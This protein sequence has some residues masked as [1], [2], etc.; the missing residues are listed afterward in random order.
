[1]TKPKI[2][3]EV[4]EKSATKKERVTLMSQSR[5][6]FAAQLK[7]WDEGK[8]KEEKRPY[9]TFRATLIMQFETKLEVS[10]PSAATM[11]NNLRKAA[12]ADNP[13]LVLQRDPKI[14]RVKS[15][16]G[17]GRPAGTKTKAESKETETA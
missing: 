9:G 15:E 5:K 2:E 11:F 17:P 13:D 8:F 1:M 4:V 6:L 3:N 14:V 12:L 7:R 16:R 10:T